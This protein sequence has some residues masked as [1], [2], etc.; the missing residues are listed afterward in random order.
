MLLDGFADKNT[1]TWS[2]ITSRERTVQPLSML[3]SSM[4]AF[5]FSATSPTSTFFRY[6]GHQMI[7]Y[8]RL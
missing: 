1:W 6:F 3:L 4:N 8:D 5:N 7:W 2:G